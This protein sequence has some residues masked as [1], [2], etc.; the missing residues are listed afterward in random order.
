MSTDR[1]RPPPEAVFFCTQL[2]KTKVLGG[3]LERVNAC[4]PAGN[5]KEPFWEL[6]TQHWPTGKNCP[7]PQHLTQVG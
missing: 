5:R 6:P 1:K 4:S 2:N 3:S 7:E